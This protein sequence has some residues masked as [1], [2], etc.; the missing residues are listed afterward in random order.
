MISSPQVGKPLWGINKPMPENAKTRA[1]VDSNEQAFSF[2]ES[3]NVNI[4]Q[5]DEMLIPVRVALLRT[6]KAFRDFVDLPGLNILDV[7]MTG[8]LAAYNYTEFS[9]VDLHL[10]VDYGTSTCPELAENFFATKKSLWNQVHDVEIKGFPV[11]VYVEDAAH[12]VTAQGVY[13]VLHGHWI[14]RPRR[15]PPKVDDNAVMSKVEALADQIETLLMGEPSDQDIRTL[16]DRL[17]RFRQSGLKKAGEFSVE[18]LTFKTL[19]NLGF[20]DRLHRAKLDAQD[21]SLSLEQADPC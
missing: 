12:P 7:A 9:D 2:H 15:E 18:N 1:H 6:A 10:I 20:L 4:W 11:E 21:R 19:R 17:K 8:S 5:S 3:L 16:L 14:K 13:S